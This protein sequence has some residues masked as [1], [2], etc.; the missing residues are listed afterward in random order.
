MIITTDNKRLS[1]KMKYFFLL[2]EEMGERYAEGEEDLN[3][4]FFSEE[5]IGILRLI[6][7]AK[8][9]DNDLRENYP[10]QMKVHLVDGRI[11]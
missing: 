10:L 5:F 7:K 11:F 3:K 6:L 9:F 1:D 8:P 2:K 4:Y